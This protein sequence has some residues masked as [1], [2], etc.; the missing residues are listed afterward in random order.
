MDKFTAWAVVCC[1]GLLLAGC[2]QDQPAT[3]SQQMQAPAADAASE[4]LAD[5]IETSPE[6]VIGISYP[7]DAALPPGLVQ[8]MR[9]YAAQAR[10][11]LQEAL[12][13]LGNDKPRFPYE[14]SLSFTVTVDTPEMVA[15]SADGSRYTG[16]AHGEPLMARFVWLRQQQRLL[17]VDE[18][19]PAAQSQRAVAGYVEDVLLEQLDQRLQADR[20]EAEQLRQ[21]RAN[22]QQMIR[23]GTEPEASNFSQ[24]QPL[25]NRQGR[26]TALRFVFPPYQVGPYSDGTQHVDVPV[27]WLRPHLAAE[28]LHLFDDSPQP[29]LAG[30]GQGSTQ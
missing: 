20:L 7:H 14:L 21:A 23:A 17:G 5:I 8:V 1:A 25:V 11:G 4:P 2:R 27:Q 15:V 29:T 19:I 10:A 24:F 18:L 6:Q 26:V 22:A 3:P 13:A 16:G 12:D 28:W 30:T 9:E